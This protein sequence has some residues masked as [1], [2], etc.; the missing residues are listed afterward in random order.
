M[1]SPMPRIGLWVGASIAVIAALV[2]FAARPAWVLGMNGSA[3]L[4]SMG[5][6]DS[7]AFPCRPIE[8][9]V[10][11]CAGPSQTLLGL[12]SYRVTVD[13]WGCWTAMQVKEAGALGPT[14]KFS[15]CVTISDYISD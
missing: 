4:K 3:L 1:N 5:G 6:E 11:G 2:F 13:S 8:D 15:G 14:G 10:W 12:V 7:G 9:S